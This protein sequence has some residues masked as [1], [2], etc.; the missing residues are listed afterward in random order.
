MNV[1]ITSLAANNFWICE[2]KIINANKFIF[3][4]KKICKTTNWLCNTIHKLNPLKKSY[5]IQNNISFN[6][7]N[8]R[9]MN[10]LGKSCLYISKI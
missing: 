10:K 9:I 4:N 2:N 3:S 5:K 7:D 1:L 8:Q 6:K